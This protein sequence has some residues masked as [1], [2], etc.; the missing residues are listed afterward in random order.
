MPLDALDL[1]TDMDHL[2]V[3]VDIGPAQA[4][5]FPAAHPVQKQEHERGVQRIVAGS[6]EE[7]QRFGWCPRHDDARFPGGQR[8]TPTTIR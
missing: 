4:E 1:L 3:E 7:G 2:A 8:A 5:D 6:V